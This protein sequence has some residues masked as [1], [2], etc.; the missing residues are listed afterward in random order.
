MYNQQELINLQE[1]IKTSVVD[2]LNSSELVYSEYLQKVI[3]DFLKA[4]ITNIDSME[5][6]LEAIFL[7]HYSDVN[8]WELNGEHPEEDESANSETK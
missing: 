5:A 8:I 6:T 7:M 2:L 3:A 1:K 4:I